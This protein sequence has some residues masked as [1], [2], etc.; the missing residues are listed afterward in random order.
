MIKV[1]HFSMAVACF[2]CI[3]QLQVTD[4]FQTSRLCSR[5]VE[6]NGHLTLFSTISGVGSDILVYDDTL[7][8]STLS[9]VDSQ[10]RVGALGHSTLQRYTPRT[11][12]EAAIESILEKLG[13][14][15]PYVE[16]WWRD[17]WLNLE[18][19]KDIDELLYRNEPGNI[20]YPN[21]GHVLYGIIPE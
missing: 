2:S 8:R 1:S 16:Y 11:A 4:T 15:S 3:C 17:S 19:H 7:D 10:A 14:E 18:A 6:N 9:C 21:H 12:V 13:D 5:K 20:K